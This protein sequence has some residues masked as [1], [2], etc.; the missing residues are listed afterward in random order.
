VRERPGPRRAHKLSEE[1]VD[2]LEQALSEEPAPKM[3]Q[4]VELLRERYRLSVHVRSVERAL[5]RRRKKGLS[6]QMSQPPE[7]TRRS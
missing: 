6:M 4:L 5:A 3:S 1:V 2:F 7:K